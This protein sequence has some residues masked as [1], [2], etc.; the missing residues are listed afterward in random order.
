MALPIIE[1]DSRAMLN[2]DPLRINAPLLHRWLVAFLQDECKRVRNV[3]DVVLGLSGGLDSAVVAFLAAE[4]FGPEHVTAVRMPYKISSQDS[5]DHAQLVIDQLGVR[6]MTIPITDMVDGYANLEPDISPSR[7]G[8]LCARCRTT[9]LFDLSAKIK[10]LP[11]GTGN[12]TERLFGYFTWHADDAP[13]VNPLG[14]LLKTQVRQLAAH[15][16]V[17]NPIQQKPPSADLI[18]GQTDEGDYGISYDRADKI[19]WYLT[20]GYPKHKLIE[21]GFP[22]SDVN[23]V[24]QKVN[25]THWKRKLPTVAMVSASAIGE[26]YLRPTDY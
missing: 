23:L 6:D 9:I 21:L 16:G 7:I 1:A 17:P 4:A 12:K 13:P 10:G 18:K 11:L 5:L 22:E 20:A 19:L 26:Y 24:W 25:A 2:S 14:D 3:H 8:N 15:L